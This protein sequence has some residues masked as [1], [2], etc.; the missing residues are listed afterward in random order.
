MSSPKFAWKDG[1]KWLA[2]GGG[3]HAVSVI[4]NTA[5]GISAV[6]QNMGNGWENLTPL[7]HLGNMWVLKEPSNYRSAPNG[8]SGQSVQLEVIGK[9]GN[10][11][12]QFTVPFTCG[13]GVCG[14]Y[15]QA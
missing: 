14:S 6:K 4:Y 3:F 2:N 8:G 13:S 12:G 1:T 5:D 9:S 10:S 7:D 11:Y 15:T